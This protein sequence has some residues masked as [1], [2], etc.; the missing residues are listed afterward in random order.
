MLSAL[1]KCRCL[2]SEHADR[3]MRENSDCLQVDKGSFVATYDP[4][5]DHIAREVKQSGN[6]LVGIA[7]IMRRITSRRLLALKYPLCLDIGANIGLF[8]FTM[9]QLG[10]SCVAFEPFYGNQERMLASIEASGLHRQ[11]KLLKHG[12]GAEERKFHIVTVPGNK[13]LQTDGIMVDI[14]A[15]ASLDATKTPVLN[16]ID[17]REMR[18]DE[19]Q[20]HRLDNIWDE[21]KWKNVSV[22]KIDVEG[23]ESMVVNGGRKFFA[24]VKPQIVFMEVNRPLWN[25]NRNFGGWQSIRDVL[26]FFRDLGYCVR[27][28]DE[29]TKRGCEA[30]CFQDFS[31][32]SK[33]T[34]DVVLTYRLCK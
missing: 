2:L 27:N 26:E 5:K 7:K 32:L 24:E 25:N 28:E 16:G 29:M 22:V 19:V 13:I 34:R 21:Q 18:K 15:N 30:K 23:F 9:Q 4:K 6:Y 31:E 10:F 14:S 20:I 33:I 12:L 1:K 17:E 11:I 8:S 3:D